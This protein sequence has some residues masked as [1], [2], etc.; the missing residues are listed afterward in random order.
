MARKPLI[1]EQIRYSSDKTNHIL[2]YCKAA[3]ILFVLSWLK[4]GKYQ[5]LDGKINIINEKYIERVDACIFPCKR[6]IKSLKL[7]SLV[8][9]GSRFTHK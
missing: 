1:F 4:F 5:H 2:E 6:E 9:I 8:I 3:L 7:L